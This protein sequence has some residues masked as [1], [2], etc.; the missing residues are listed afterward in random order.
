MQFFLFWFCLFFASVV[1]AEGSF[2]VGGELNTGF[3]GGPVT[4]EFAVDTVD[5]YGGNWRGLQI[6][7]ETARIYE[8]IDPFFLLWVEGAYK[9]FE[10]KIY[11]PL[12]KDME[13]WFEDDLR[14][15]VTLNPSHLDINVPNEAFA[16]W[17]YGAGFAQ[18]GR[19]KPDTEPSPNTLALG[20]APYHDGFYFDFSPSIFRYDFFFSSLN[21][22]LHGTPSST[23]QNA[24]EG[25][26]AW[27]QAH[28]SVDNQRNRS[29]SEPYKSLVYHRLGI[30][31]KKIWFYIIEQSIIG[32][33]QAEFR[34]LSPFMFWHNNYATGYTKSNVVLELGLRPIA[35]SAFYWQ[36]AIDEI[37]SPVGEKGVDSRGI[38]SYLVGYSQKIQTQKWG[39][40]D[41]RLDLV[42]TDP[43][44]GNERLPLLKYT[45]RRMYRSNY[46]D[47]SDA[48]YADSYFVDYPLGYRRGPDAL[49]LWFTADWKFLRHGISLELAWLRQGDKETYT[50][51]DAALSS[52]KPLS[53]IVEREYLVDILYSYRLMDAFSFWCGGGGRIYR[54]LSHI[55]GDNS[56]DLWL[57]LGV[58]ISLSYTVGK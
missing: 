24:P 4:K 47:R 41:L 14:T 52:K 40:F 6:P 54:N 58:S 46:R 27:N 43:A 26:E 16:K 11:L 45:S 19:F 8:T 48:D 3:Y 9:N 25:S 20:G 38:L 7:L 57:R 17:T 21:A 33:K 30:E 51:Y 34:T 2:T 37:K 49:D 42:Y 5:R 29:Y 28:L 18:L 10:A 32:G 56:R 44:Y 35:G 12:R 15:N 13:A 23:G 22:H 31:L 39:E 53:G 50:D 55:Q 1:F 36:M